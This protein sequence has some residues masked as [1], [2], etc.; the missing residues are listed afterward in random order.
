MARA[1]TELGVTIRLNEPVREVFFNRRRA[2]AVRPPKGETRADAVVV[3]ADFGHAMTTR[4]PSALRRKWTDAT[5]ARKRFDT[6]LRTAKMSGLGIDPGGDGMVEHPTI[7]SWLRLDSGVARS[8]PSLCAICPAGIGGGGL[9]WVT[10]S[11]GTAL[12]IEEATVGK[13]K[14]PFSGKAGTCRWPT[15][16]RASGSGLSGLVWSHSP[17]NRHL[18][19]SSRMC[20]A[21]NGQFLNPRSFAMSISCEA[22]RVLQATICC[23]KQSRQDCDAAMQRVGCGSVVYRPRRVGKPSVTPPSS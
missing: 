13:S 15:S 5:L 1:A 2:V 12:E 4:V 7:D 14:A 21:Q 8:T 3:N 23:P 17:Q 16:C 6:A 11:D 10:A 20:S 18:I 19:A 22:V 9:L